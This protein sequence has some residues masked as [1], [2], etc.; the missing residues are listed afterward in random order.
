MLC[1]PTIPVHGTAGPHS[2]KLWG[3]ACAGPDHPRDNYYAAHTIVYPSMRVCRLLLTATD[4]SATKAGD[5]G[6]LSSVQLQHACSACVYPGLGAHMSCRPDSVTPVDGRLSVSTC[7]MAGDRWCCLPWMQSKTFSER[8]PTWRDRQEDSSKAA[9]EIYCG[10]ASAF[11]HQGR[12]HFWIGC[13][14]ALCYT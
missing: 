11:S 12:C 10:D 3:P 7:N 14:G 1:S 5:S 4:V 8:D 13:F 6:A 2:G 9:C